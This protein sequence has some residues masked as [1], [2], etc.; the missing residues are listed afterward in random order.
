[1]ELPTN[2]I[3]ESN[4]DARYFII[5]YEMF[6]NTKIN[7]DVSK[8]TENNL[9]EIY[10]KI[11]NDKK[12]PVNKLIDIS[13]HET[14]WIISGIYENY[15]S[16][17]NEEEIT[18]AAN[19]IENISVSDCIEN[20]THFNNEIFNLYSKTISIRSYTEFCKNKKLVDTSAFKFPTY[21]SKYSN[22]R[23]HCISNNKITKKMKEINI[24]FSYC[25]HYQY[26]FKYILLSSQIMNSDKSNIETIVRRIIKK[27]ELYNLS[28]EDFYTLIRP[29]IF[30]GSD[31][32]PYTRFL[33]KTSLY[34]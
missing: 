28:I 13:L 1:M 32:R 2:I 26:Y 18:S 8:E 34:F 9:W 15:I 5:S 16:I 4:G 29:N 23:V 30:C 14:N 19:L 11:T 31:L 24:S 25:N 12:T 3:K 21:Y 20:F 33:K 27:L 22:Y 17:F 7:G 10:N 6:Y